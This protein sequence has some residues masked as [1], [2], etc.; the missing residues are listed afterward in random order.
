MIGWEDIS[1]DRL[2]EILAAEREG[3]CVVLP[4][5]V[6]DKLYAIRTTARPHRRRVQEEIIDQ[7]TITENG[8]II[9]TENGFEQHWSELNMTFCLTRDEAD[10]VLNPRRCIYKTNDGHCTLHSDITAMEYCIEGPCPD[11]EMS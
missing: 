11:E 8:I 6:G 3:R 4:C 2:A 7:I 1:M 10:A 5:K 9:G